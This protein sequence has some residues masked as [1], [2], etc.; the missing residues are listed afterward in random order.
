V[1]GLFLVPSIITHSLLS[2]SYSKVVCLLLKLLSFGKA[3][4][5]FFSLPIVTSL[6][7]LGSKICFGSGFNSFLE[8]L[9]ISNLL[10]SIGVI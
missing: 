5:Q 4:L 10:S 8:T 3:K 7:V 6:I 1:L 2:S 9:T